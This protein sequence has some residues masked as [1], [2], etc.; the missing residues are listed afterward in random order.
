LTTDVLLEDEAVD[1]AVQTLNQIQT[2]VAHATREPWPAVAGPGY[3]GFPEPNAEVVGDEIRMWFGN[4]E[5]PVLELGPFDV[6]DVI[7]RE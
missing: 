4:R 6:S 1:G 5:R 3:A 7:L 2:H